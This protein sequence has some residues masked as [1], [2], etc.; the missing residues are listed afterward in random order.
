MLSSEAAPQ[1]RSTDSP[2]AYASNSRHGLFD[3]LKIL[4]LSAFSRIL[5]K[6]R[7]PLPP[8]PHRFFIAGLKQPISEARMDS[9]M[10]HFWA[11]LSELSL[12]A[13]RQSRAL[14]S[15]ASA[16]AELRLVAAAA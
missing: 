10:T 11:G 3:R 14:T 9:L 2:P 13:T 7:S 15:L 1:T 16:L 4:Y 12:I 8:T 6:G 5:K